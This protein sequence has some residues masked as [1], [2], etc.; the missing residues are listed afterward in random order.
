MTKQ[1]RESPRLRI[2]NTEDMEPLSPGKKPKENSLVSFE[3]MIEDSKK[4]HNS[5]RSIKKIG[6]RKSFVQSVENTLR[7]K[8]NAIRIQAQLETNTR[9]KN[10]K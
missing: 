6:K 4:R 5:S 8:I 3:N 2:R 10:K 1:E 9:K 7:V